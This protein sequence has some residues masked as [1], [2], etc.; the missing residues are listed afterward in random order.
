MVSDFSAL[1]TQAKKMIPLAL[2]M[3]QQIAPGG[4][5]EEEKEESRRTNTHDAVSQSSSDDA[6]MGTLGR[7][8]SFVRLFVCLFVCLKI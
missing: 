7:V 5:Q 3:V 2:K 1:A 4:G 8:R 6:G